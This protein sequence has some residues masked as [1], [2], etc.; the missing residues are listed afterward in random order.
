MCV[1]YKPEDYSILFFQRKRNK[2]AAESSS[3]PVANASK[4]M[5]L[6]L[7]ESMKTVLLIMATFTEEQAD[8]I[9]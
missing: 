1:Y 6:K 7:S 5:K 9:V 2:A 8:A 3:K 4:S